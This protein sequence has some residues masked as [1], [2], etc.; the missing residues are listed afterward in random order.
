[1]S[2][3]ARRPTLI[4]SHHN[5]AHQKHATHT[6][7]IAC[8]N[9]D[10]NAHFFHCTLP[11]QCQRKHLDTSDTSQSTTWHHYLLLR[12]TL[13]HINTNTSLPSPSLYIHRRQ[14]RFRHW[15]HRPQLPSCPVSTLS[16][17]SLPLILS[18]TK[19]G[20]DVSRQS[21]HFL[22]ELRH[23]Y[24]RNTTTTNDTTSQAVIHSCT[25]S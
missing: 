15:L 21:R 14:A 5:S 9:Q 23:R 19:Y 20:N 10:K 13:C 12:P 8:N 22:G 3:W 1:M 2:S 16:D 11:L 17:R 24:W 7:V 6:D 4:H 18:F 25:N